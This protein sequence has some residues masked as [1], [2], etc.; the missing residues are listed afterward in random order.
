[1]LERYDFILNGYKNH[2]KKCNNKITIE[3]EYFHVF[4]YC[5]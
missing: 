3:E 1:M 2:Y 5:V 4:K